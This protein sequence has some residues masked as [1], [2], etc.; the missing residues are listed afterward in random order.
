MP[1]RKPSPVCNPPPCTHSSTGLWSLLLA[2]LVVYTYRYRQSSVPICFALSDWMHMDGNVVVSRG[3]A[4]LWGGWGAAHRRSPTGGAAK[5]ILRKIRRPVGKVSGIT[6]PYFVWYISTE[7]AE[8]IEATNSKEN[9]R[10]IL[11]KFVRR[12]ELP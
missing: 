6:G 2:A 12:L 9:S 1:P 10:I 3:E 4:H 7:I 11:D 8:D 5:G